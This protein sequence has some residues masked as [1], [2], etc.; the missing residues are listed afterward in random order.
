M[1]GGWSRGPTMGALRAAVLAATT[2]CGLSH[3]A[4]VRWSDK[5]VQYAAVEPKDLRMF[6][7]EFA[8]QQGMAVSIDPEVKGELTGRYNLS[9]RSMIELLSRTYGLIHYFDGKVLYVSPATAVDS[10]VIRL[11]ETTP[12]QFQ[13]TLERLGIADSRYPL[14]FDAD[15][16]T[17]MV[18]GPRRM[19]ELVRQT[20]AATERRASASAE[21]PQS[22]TRVF[23]L[24]YAFAE[25]HVVRSAGREMRVPGVA[26]VL[27]QTFAAGWR[28]TPAL[29]ATPQPQRPLQAAEQQP[30]TNLPMLPVLPSGR[31]AGGSLGGS[32]T[33]DEAPA[34][35]AVTS[36]PTL[37]T[38]SADARTNS[39][40][41]RDLPGR[42]A[43][44]EELIRALDE[45][46]RLV[47]L[48][49][50]I[51]EVN[52][53]DFVTLGIDWKVL[54]REASLE[55]GSG[56]L[57]SS[58][59]NPRGVTPDPALLLNTLPTVGSVQG[60]AFALVTGGR[61]Q[62]IARISALEQ[63]GRAN[64]R[65]QPRLITLNN[66]EAVLESTNTF[67]VRV[68]GFQDAQLFDVNVGTAIRLTP[69]V[70]EAALDP[71]KPDQVS[72]LV[73]MLVRIEDGSIT[74]QVVSG[75]PVVQR[76]NI[77]TQAIVIDGT[78]LLIAGYSQER[79]REIENAVPG[80]SRIPLL[81]AL[82]RSK[83]SAQQRL[84][85][86]FMITPRIVDLARV[87]VARPAP[88]GG[89]SWQ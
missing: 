89:A 79:Q 30:P 65:A 52:G 2:V 48:E 75:L 18:S 83:S 77:G 28:G 3:A 84:E 67:Y 73:R 19:V 51:V 66:V 14:T 36:H 82:F 85:R 76:S 17:V 62:L 21:N 45:R 20:A 46:P 88:L 61:S 7:R 56:G 1:N 5:L 74:D 39:I 23:Q 78:T 6:L 50:N 69:S 34:T 59:N 55:V 13:R 27:R 44:Y 54:G 24:R 26:S 29:G 35:P 43:A 63:G 42:L 25:D 4:D 58:V 11:G 41:V 87:G 49:V 22:A 37:P 81:G 80:L 9:P 64:V 38:F 10:E 71:A 60:A 16:G 33:V 57:A 40:I 31:R 86:L 70:V 12:A 32:G 68:E 53:D 47:E 15:R 72:A 8:A